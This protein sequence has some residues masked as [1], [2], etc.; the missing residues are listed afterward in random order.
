MEIASSDFD[1]V[2]DFNDSVLR[3]EFS[4]YIFVWLLNSF[5]GLYDIES[6]YQVH[7]HR[8][9]VAYQSQYGCRL[10]LAVMDIQVHA[11]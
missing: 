9:G 1:S 7:I 4:V 11:L 10:T 8:S 2:C 6:V 5:D 3:M